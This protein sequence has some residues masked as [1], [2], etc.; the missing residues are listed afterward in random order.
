M[1]VDT[2]A[3]IA[4][5]GA[6][7]IGLEAALYARVLGYEVRIF[8]QH[9]IVGTLRRGDPA[10]QV[11]WRESTSPLGIA[12]LSAQDPRW[13]P[14][15]PEAA[16]SPA[17]LAERY[18]LLLAQSDLLVDSL[19]LGSAVIGIERDL[20]P[21]E[22]VEEDEV[23]GF[24]LRI[25]TASSE[26]EETVDVVIDASGPAV[27]SEADSLAFGALLGTKRGQSTAG[28]LSPQRLLT[29]EADYYVLGAK[30]APVQS[31]FRFVDGLAQVR[32]LFT[33]IADRASLDLY[34]RTAAL[35]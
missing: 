14:P 29:A 7:P 35:S 25:R 2:P 21:G 18:F 12:A 20:S 5:I 11:V 22:V 30:S 19:Y 31:E 9:E 26:T 34:A 16:I 10:R 23:A 17:D 33:I 13:Q 15:E 1:A 6:G 3:T 27:T 4:V 28:D 24:R 8:E 32:D